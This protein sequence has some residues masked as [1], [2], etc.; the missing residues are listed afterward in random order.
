M[1]SPE[2]IPFFFIIG[3]PRSGTYLLRSLFD[4]HPNVVIPTECPLIV[5]LYPKWGGTKQWNKKKLLRFYDDILF[6]KEFHKWNLDQ[7][8]LKK[9][10]LTFTGKHS[11][12]TLIKVIY[13]HSESGFE[14]KEISLIGD[15]NPV[16]ST[17]T[18]KVIKV[19]PEAKYIHLTRDYRDNLVSIKKV[20]FEAPY[21]PLIAYRWKHSARLLH[22]LKKLHSA[23]FYTFKYDDLVSQPQQEMK[24]LCK[25]LEIPYH[26]EVFDFYK[27]RDA[28]FKNHPDKELKTYHQSLSN[29]I[30][31]KKIGVW[32]KSLSAKEVKMLET[33]IGEYAELSGYERIYRNKKA[34]MRL[35]ALPGILY[36]KASYLF[37]D[38]LDLLPFRIR[39]KVKQ[40]G[41]LMAFV[42]HK[43]SG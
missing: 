7:E 17:N 22:K 13:L 20:D 14:K 40:A 39:V 6:H 3:R 5:N 30:N 18:E 42:Y 41:S 21:T 19:F 27:Q 8:A 26:E 2:K 4:A 9:N 11:F 36:G 31:N 25:F 1:K 35:K 28:S 37:A 16:Y 10:L 24:K 15:K 43:L 23:V 12:Q 29:P 34:D 32:E 38:F 33:V